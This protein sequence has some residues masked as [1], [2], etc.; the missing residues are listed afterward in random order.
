MA[1]DPYQPVAFRRL[2]DADNRGWRH[3][4][5]L[6]NQVVKTG[7][8]TDI[9]VEQVTENMENFARIALFH[10]LDII[11]QMKSNLIELVDQERDIFTMLLDGGV[12]AAAEIP[13]AT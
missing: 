6:V 13:I 4:M 12:Q 5:A 11:Y 10:M 7:I 1:I 9:S 8:D 2:S 3:L